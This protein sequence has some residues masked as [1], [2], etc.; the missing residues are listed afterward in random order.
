MHAIAWQVRQQCPGGAVLYLS[1]EKF[2][3]RFVS[4]LR[5]KDM[6]GF[7]EKF[8]S[9][10]MLMVDDVQFISGKDSTQ[11]EFFHTFNALVDAEA[12]RHLRRQGAGE[13]DGLE[14][15]IARGSAGAWSSTCTRPTTSSASASCR[16]R[17]RQSE[18]CG[19]PSA[20]G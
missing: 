11:E 8:R 6:H 7:K 15:R 17:P 3:Y 12:D 13:I 18:A 9:V 16:P 4:A 20:Q 1:A 5:F 10:D 14:E 19:V 2:M